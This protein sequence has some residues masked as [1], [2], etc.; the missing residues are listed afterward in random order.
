VTLEADGRV[1]LRLDES[2]DGEGVR[3]LRH[4]LRGMPP[5][6]RDRLGGLHEYMQ[7]A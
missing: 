7:V 5:L 3:R 4:K 2:G 1:R 6:R